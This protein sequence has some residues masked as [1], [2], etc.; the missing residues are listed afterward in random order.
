MARGCLCK[1][2]SWPAPAPPPPPPRMEW[3]IY[4]SLNGE[5]RGEKWGGVDQR[6]CKWRACKPRSA[7]PLWASSPLT[8]APQ[9]GLLSGKQRQGLCREWP[10]P[11]VCFISSLLRPLLD[12]FPNS[13]FYFCFFSHFLYSTI[14]WSLAVTTGKTSKR[15]MSILLIL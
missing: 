4:W 14:P 11:T 9:P 5:K 7:R 6:K 8:A 1:Y 3:H 10:G 12:T 13:Q 2:L 15:L